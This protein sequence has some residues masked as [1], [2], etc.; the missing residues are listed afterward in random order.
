[1]C[2]KRGIKTVFYQDVDLDNFYQ[3]EFY[4]NAECAHVNFI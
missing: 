1:M 2:H 3:N 4:Q